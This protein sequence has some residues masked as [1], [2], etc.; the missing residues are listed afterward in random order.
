[1]RVGLGDEEDGELIAAEP[2]ERV[3]R[4]Q[5]AGEPAAKGE[6]HAVADDEAEALIDVLEAVDVDE[7]HGRAIGLALAGAGDG[8]GHAVHEQLAVGEPGQAVMHGVVHQPLMRA[9][10]AG[11]VAHQPDAAEQPGIV[12]WRRVGAEVVP[13]I[14]AV[15][16]PEAEIEQE[17]AAL[18][19]LQRPQHQAEALAVGGVHMLEELIDRYVQRAGI[20]AELLLDLL[21]D[22]D[23][24]LA[25]AP[26][27]DV[28]A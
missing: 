25:G 28:G 17:V 7:H 23:L 1:M 18:L 24:V 10:E 20:E 2:G 5:M 3:L 6:Q 11:H 12:A 19:L 22:G 9:L 16:A 4:V 13:E 26:L 14:G 21:G 27:E 15:V 8:A